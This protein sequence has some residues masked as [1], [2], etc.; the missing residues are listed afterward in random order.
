MKKN[1]NHIT[2]KIYFKLEGFGESTVLEES[3]EKTLMTI[4][5]RIDHKNKLNIRNYDFYYFTEHKDNNQFDDNDDLDNEINM[6]TQIKFLT[7]YELEVSFILQLKAE[8]T[9]LLFL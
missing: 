5:E 2:L 4:L 6:E 1:E 7:V 9:F 3:E 8:I